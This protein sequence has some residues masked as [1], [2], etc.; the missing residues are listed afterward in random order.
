MSDDITS[1][2]RTLFLWCRYSHNKSAINEPPGMISS[3]NA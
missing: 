1:E 3:I 2:S